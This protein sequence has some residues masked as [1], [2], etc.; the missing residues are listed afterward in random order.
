MGDIRRS[1]ATQTKNR[2]ASTLMEQ[3]VEYSKPKLHGKRYFQQLLSQLQQV[4]EPVRQTLR[5]SRGSL[6][7]FDVT[8]RLLL[9]QLQA[10]PKL[11]KRLDLPRTIPGVG[12][13]T[14]LT[15][16]LEIGDPHRFRSA[17]KAMSYCGLVS[18]LQ[19]SAGKHYRQPLS[20]KRNPHPRTML[21]E[22]AHLVPRYVPALKAL[23]DQVKEKGDAGEAVIQVARK[24]VSYLELVP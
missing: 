11:S 4:P 7:M 3:G 5:Y 9:K 20:K 1:E 18:P 23:Y 10:D 2:I 16:A 8:Q 14:A 21:I 6:E 15:W 13:I 24:L 17:G 12:Q 22:A 19:E